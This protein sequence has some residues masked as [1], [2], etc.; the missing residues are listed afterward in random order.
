MRIICPIHGLQKATYISPDLWETSKSI[1]NVEVIYEYDGQHVNAF[2]LSEDFA[3]KHEIKGGVSALP[4]DYPLWT[5][6]TTSVCEKCF[7]ERQGGNR[8]H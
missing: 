8:G 5:E 2:L 1:H 7:E 6:Q 4:N 3:K